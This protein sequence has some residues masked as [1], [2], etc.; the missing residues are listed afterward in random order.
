MEINYNE[1]GTITY[2]K[3][4]TRTA[5]MTF[6]D[7]SVESSTPVY[8]VSIEIYFS[9]EWES[10]LADENYSYHISGNKIVVERL[11]S[12]DVIWIGY[13]YQQWSS[14]Q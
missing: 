2:V 8:S 4:G 6:G 9:P 1:N 11:R 3:L 10:F 13:R 5:K 7:L 12:D 14:R